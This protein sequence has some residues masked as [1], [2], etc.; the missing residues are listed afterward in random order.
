[1]AKAKH[2]KGA[3]KGKGTKGNKGKGMKAMAK[4]RMKKK[5]QEQQAQREGPSRI[6]GA[7]EY[8]SKWSRRDEEEVDWKFNKVKQATLL[9]FWPDRQK[10]PSDVFSQQLL[11][12]LKS[13]PETGLERTIAQARAIVEDASASATQEVDAQGAEDE[14][15]SEEARQLAAESSALRK[16][17]HARALKVI[18]ALLQET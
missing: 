18:A 16:I 9:R 3:R 13:L 14:N 11:P 6:E 17:R 5:Q 10:V 8:L 2:I 4:L 15:D 1:M 12:Y 7:L